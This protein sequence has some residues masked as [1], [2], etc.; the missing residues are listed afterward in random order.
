MICTHADQECELCET[1]RLLSAAKAGALAIPRLEQKLKDLRHPLKAVALAKFKAAVL[2][3]TE[4][5][6][7]TEI[8]CVALMECRRICDAQTREAK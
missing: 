6:D 5:L 2:E 8:N 3:A 1:E 4:H 7:W